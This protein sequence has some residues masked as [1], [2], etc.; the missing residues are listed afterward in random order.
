[1]KMVS[2]VCSISSRLVRHLDLNAGET[3]WLIKQVLKG[4]KIREKQ[5]IETSIHMEN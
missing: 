5:P 1:M 3:S 2:F 4:T